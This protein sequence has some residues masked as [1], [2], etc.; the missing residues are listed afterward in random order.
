MMTNR[1]YEKAIIFAARAHDG[2]TRKGDGAPY[3]THPY[4]VAFMLAEQEC[5]DEAIIAG[6]LHDTVEDTSVTLEDIHRQFG[7]GIAHIVEI[8][9]EPDKSLQWEERKRHTIQVVKTAPVDAKYVVC[10]D[11][12]HNLRSLMAAH[13]RLGDDV[14]SRFSRGYAEQRWYA[15]SLVQSIF[16]GLDK[17][18][19]KPMLLEYKKLVEEFFNN[20]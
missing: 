5:S 18:E 20:E 1:L 11:K 13:Q 14:W 17:T 6:L 19:I 4:T 16:Y 2:Q 10:A 3:I 15:E 9:S 7:G 8:C 12:L